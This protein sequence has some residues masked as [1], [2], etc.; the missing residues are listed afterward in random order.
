MENGQPMTTGMLRKRFDDVRED[1]SI[2]KA[3]FQMR[4]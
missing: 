3:D 4:D 2:P 1:A